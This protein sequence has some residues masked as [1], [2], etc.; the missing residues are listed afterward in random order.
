M[1]R[2][3][4]VGGSGYGQ[5]VIA[6]RQLGVEHRVVKQGHATVRRRSAVQRVIVGR[7]ELQLAVGAGLEE[8]EPRV[9]RGTD[10]PGK[11]LGEEGVTA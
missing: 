9:E 2:I 11:G 3:G 4:H 5:I 7:K 6:L 8:A 1:R 10:A